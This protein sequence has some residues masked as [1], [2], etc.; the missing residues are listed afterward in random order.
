MVYHNPDWIE[1][2]GHQKIGDEVHG[3]EGE[4]AGMFW[5]DRLQG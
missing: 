4:R 2:L 3:D 1:S 5:S